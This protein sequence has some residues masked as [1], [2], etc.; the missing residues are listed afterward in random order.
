MADG[1]ALAALPALPSVSE[2]WAAFFALPNVAQQRLSV[3]LQKSLL[4]AQREC[5][6]TD[7]MFVLDKTSS[8]YEHLRDIG[9]TPGAMDELKAFV[10][11]VFPEDLTV[12]GQP[13]TAAPFPSAVTSPRCRC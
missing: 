2:D 1:D 9:V 6:P 11:R 7:L 5:L 10:Q 8:V 4:L 3:R 12:A 13:A